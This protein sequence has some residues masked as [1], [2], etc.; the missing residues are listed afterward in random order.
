MKGGD[1]SHQSPVHFLR[2]G[3]ILVIG[4]QASLDMA[5]WDLLIKGRQ[6][7]G[8][9]RGRVAVD[10]DKIGFDGIQNAVHAEKR[11]CGNGGKRLA[12]FHDMQVIIA[13]QLK[14]LHDGIEHFPV[15]AGQADDA[16]DLLAGLQRLDKRRHFDGL[17]PCAEDGHDFQLIH[18][19]PPVFLPA[20]PP[21]DRSSRRSA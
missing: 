13:R 6:R 5:D 20:R 11:L 1:I 16:F 8:K 14:D 10:E 7:P 18:A 12:L 17:R 9:R 4:P 19:V 21:T 15:L 2:K 3:G